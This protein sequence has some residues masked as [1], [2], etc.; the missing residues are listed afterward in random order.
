MTEAAYVRSTVGLTQ[1]ALRADVQ[2][3]QPRVTP[4]NEFRWARASRRGNEDG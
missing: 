2:R 3:D 4:A 1:K